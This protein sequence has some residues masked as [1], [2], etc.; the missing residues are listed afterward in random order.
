MA[1]EQV[2]IDWNDANGERAKV[3]KPLLRTSPCR[4]CRHLDCPY[5]NDLHVRRPKR[6]PVVQ[7]KA[8]VQNP[9]VTQMVPVTFSK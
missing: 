9:F 4:R 8:P 6:K 7:D 3:V 2:L 1:D 5:G